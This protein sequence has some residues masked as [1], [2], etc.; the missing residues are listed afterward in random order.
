MDSISLRRAAGHRIQFDSC[1]HVWRSSVGDQQAGPTLRWDPDCFDP[2]CPTARWRDHPRSGFGQ[3]LPVAPARHHHECGQ[4]DLGL[5]QRHE[6]PRDVALGASSPGEVGQ[7]HHKFI[8]TNP[9]D[10]IGGANGVANG[11]G[12]RSQNTVASFIAIAVVPLFEV[13]HVQLQNAERMPLP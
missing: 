13:V 6:A 7:N 4:A 11:F 2:K 10:L 5:L 8:T 1:H 12:K 9:S 3:A